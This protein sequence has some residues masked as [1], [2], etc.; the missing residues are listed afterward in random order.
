MNQLETVLKQ[1]KNNKSK[2]PLD[3]PNEL[4]KQM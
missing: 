4:F 1:L 2:D 3:L